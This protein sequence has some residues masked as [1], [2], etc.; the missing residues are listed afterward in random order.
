MK[1][2]NKLL[3][4]VMI[5]IFVMT[6]RNIYAEL[7]I[8][9]N[10]G[11]IA[12]TDNQ[13]DEDHLLRENPEMRTIF[14]NKERYPDILLEML[15]RNPDMIDYVLK[16]EENKGKV[17]AKTIGRVSQGKY[18]LLLQYD[19][20]WGYGMYGNNVIAINGCGPTSVAMIVAGL[21]GRNDLTPYDIA[22]YAYNHGYY[23]DGT[24]WSFFAEGVKEFGLIGQ[25]LPLS[26]SNMMNVLKQGKPMICS[27]RKGDFTTTG[28]IITI[29]GVKD[30]Q[31]VIN[32]PNSQERSHMLWDYE[33][34]ESQ[35]KNVWFFEK[36]I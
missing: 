17:F 35:I 31:F 12:L 28:H 19:T 1:R 18:P 36:C 7:K 30:G 13:R 32:D 9:E 2:K 8:F 14:E 3:L 25:E 22:K 27:M 24:A 21:T 29:V 10:N 4:I 15:S 33:R 11:E 34:I 16:Y 5:F 26:K 23:Q 6:V 20:R